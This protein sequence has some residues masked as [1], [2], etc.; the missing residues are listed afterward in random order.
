MHFL[1]R[2]LRLVHLVLDYLCLFV[3]P[4]MAGTDLTTCLQIPGFTK[5]FLLKTVLA[6]IRYLMLVDMSI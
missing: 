2:I 1:L 3:F 6:S 4:Q 5:V